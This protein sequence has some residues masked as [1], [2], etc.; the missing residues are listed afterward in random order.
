M[1]G[2]MP[3]WNVQKAVERA[4]MWYREFYENNRVST[5]DDLE[6]Y[7]REARKKELPWTG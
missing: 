7:I 3:V 6:L 1:L 4:V 5:S 2:W